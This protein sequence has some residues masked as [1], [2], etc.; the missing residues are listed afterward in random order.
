MSLA[1][2]C[3][4]ELIGTFFL[5]LVV[6]TAA[7]GGMAGGMAPFAI[8]GIL[9][10][11]IYMAGP[12]SG[13]HFN[14]AVTLGFLVRGGLPAREVVPYILAQLIGAFLAAMVQMVLLENAGSA[15]GALAL[16]A[17]GEEGGRIADALQVGI[18]ELLFTFALVLVIL[19]VASAPGQAPNQYFGLAI[20]VT[21]MA[22]AFAVGPVSGAVFNPA[23]LL[24]LWSLGATSGV[25]FAVILAT[26]LCGGLLAALTFRAVHGIEASPGEG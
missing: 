3:G 24:G 20:A 4:L 11:M 17:L 13:G 8:G 6:A 19:N 12:H 7:V 5:M 1:A 10:A 21:V 26:T 16:A 15:D 9:M 25:M 22:G 2:R 18:A 23:V 14:P